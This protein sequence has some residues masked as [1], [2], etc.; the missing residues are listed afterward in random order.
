MKVNEVFTPRSSQVNLKTYV[1][2]L[3]LERALLRSVQGTMHAVLFGESG[4]GKSWLY[5]KVLD[6]HGIHFKVA[7]CANASRMKSLTNEIVNTL[8]P[9]GSAQK[10][11][12]SKGCVRKGRRRGGEALASGPISGSSG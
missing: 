8:L 3:S 6:Q 9:A 1:P 5:K 10:T 12:Y 11:G 4:N 7:N 2:R